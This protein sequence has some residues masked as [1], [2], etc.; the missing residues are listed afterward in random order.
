MEK[1]GNT[2]F[3][4]E[5]CVMNGV[6]TADGKEKVGHLVLIDPDGNQAQVEWEG[7]T[8]QWVSLS[9]ISKR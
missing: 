6:K 3:P 1:H 5:P 7:G 9:D 8:T 4:G 2:W